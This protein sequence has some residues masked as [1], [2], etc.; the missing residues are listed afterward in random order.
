MSRIPERLK[1]KP[2]KNSQKN[3]CFLSSYTYIFNG[4][5]DFFTQ[6]SLIQCCH[7]L[8]NVLLDILTTKRTMTRYMDEYSIIISTFTTFTST[9]STST[10]STSRLTISTFSFS[11]IL[12]DL[13]RTCSTKVNSKFEV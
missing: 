1:C 10:T 9:T 6:H 5:D 8:S 4:S 13:L 3:H 7:I 12:L 11:L 2:E